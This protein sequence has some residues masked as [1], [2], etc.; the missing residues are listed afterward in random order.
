ML[1]TPLTLAALLCTVLL[2]AAC[3]PQ[4]TTTAAVEGQPQ[5]ADP[6]VIDQAQTYLATSDNGFEVP[7]IPVEQVPETYRRQVVDYPTEQL[8]GTIVINP[9]QRVLYFVISPTKAIRYGIAVGR[10]GFE[11]SGEAVI[12]ERKPWP[13]WTPPP[14]MI[15]R[16]P[17]LAKWEEGQPGGPTNPLGARALYLTTNGVDYGYRIHGT[18]EWN[19]IGSNAS[20]GCIRM[21]NQDVIDLYSRVPDGAKV[22][23][24]TRDGQMPT[25]LTLPPPQPRRE[26]P[27]RTA[28]VA[29]PVTPAEPTLPPPPALPPLDPELIG[30]TPVTPA[31]PVTPAPVAGAAVTP[32]P[33]APAPAV[34]KPVVPAA[35]AAV[36]PTPVVPAPSAPAA[37][38]VCVPTA[39]KPCPPPSN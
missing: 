21:I 15:E 28:R 14:E 27:R 32:A 4:A 2:A 9:A 18:P 16:K 1:R 7:A 17:E 11:W 39:A 23:V 8:P 37:P 38:T 26:T 34:P 12:T 20:S 29:A 31:S 33:I 36:T 22:I 13:T 30:T 6:G 19:S 24:M 10:D 35:P 25:G 3:V 5:I